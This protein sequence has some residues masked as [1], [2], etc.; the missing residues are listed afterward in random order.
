MTMSHPGTPSVS[1]P[2]AAGNAALRAGQ[3]EQAMR[4]YL[5]AARE[6]PALAALVRG[7]LELLGLRRRREQLVGLPAGTPR[8]SPIVVVCA[9]G[10]PPSDMAA[11]QAIIRAY[12]PLFG[13][14][15]ALS[16]SLLTESS[17]GAGDAIAMLPARHQQ[18]VL[19]AATPVLAALREHV[20]THPADLVHL[21][22]P[23]NG[24]QL[25]FGL[26]QQALWRA[27]VIVDG[28][29]P[30]VANPPEFSASTAADGVPPAFAHR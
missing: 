1:S 27:R 29:T 7:N 8:P 19:P 3:F 11:A 25:L 30:R 20:I 21:A 18:L 15:S 23:I 4:L 26:F 5:D 17:S 28:T 16:L 14:A 10:L 2:L 12:A 13:H 24:L 9:L 6:R 22:G